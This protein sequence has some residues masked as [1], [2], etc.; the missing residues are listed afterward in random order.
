MIVIYVTC[1]T[2]QSAREISRTLL[3]QKL[4]ACT[5][6]L[7][8]MESH[9]LWQNEIKK[10]TEVVL[11]IKAVSENFPRIENM[12]KELHPYEVPCIFSLKTDLAS[13]S[14]LQWIRSSCETL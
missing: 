7:P 11:L 13:E 4:I 9:Y 10:E 6:I 2:I 12:I 1:P 14:Y 5:N 3:N 8:K